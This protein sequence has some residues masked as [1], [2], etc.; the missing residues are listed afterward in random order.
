M[1]ANRHNVRVLG[2]LL[3]VAS[4]AACSAFAPSAPAEV[5]D[6]E[7]AGYPDGADRRDCVRQAEAALDL[8][9]PSGDMY[10]QTRK[11]MRLELIDRCMRKRGHAP[12]AVTH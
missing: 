1:S 9:G 11:A 2:A 5:N 4:I 12:G 6:F 8:R 10:Y 3:M 7:Y